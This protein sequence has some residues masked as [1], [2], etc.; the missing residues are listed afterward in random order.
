MTGFIYSIALNLTGQNSVMKAVEVTDRLDKSVNRVKGDSVAMGTAMEQAGRK[1]RASFDGM[2]SSLK[3]WIATA[4]IGLALMGSM[5]TAAAFEGTQNAIV[6]ASGSAE[7]GAK[8]IGFVRSEAERLGLQLD[9]SLNGFKLL[10]GAMRDVPADRVQNIFR[11]VMTGASAM[12]LSAEDANGVLLALSQIASKGKVQA[13]ELR[14]QI[15]ERIPGAFGIAARAMGVSEAALNK[16]METG[17]LASKDFLPRFAAQMEKEFG[18]AIAKSSQGATANFNRMSNAIFDLKVKFG[19][20]LLPAAIPFI[21]DFLIPGVTWIGQNI[22]L[23]LGLGVALTSAYTAYKLVTIAQAAWAAISTVVA[24]VTTGLTTGVWALN[25]AMYANPIGIV[26]ALLVGLA[27]A[28]VW[29]WNK[30]E[31]FRGFLLGMNEVFLEFHRIIYDFAIAPL[32]AMGKT[33]I[34]VFTFDK[35]MIAAGLMDS[36]ASFE[37]VSQGVGE[38]V[39]AAYQKGYGKGIAMDAIKMP[40]FLGGTTDAVSKAFGGNAP[41][42]GGTGGTGKD[43]GM[44]KGIEGI[45]GGGSKNITISVNK[46]VESLTIQSQNVKE[47]AGEMREIVIRELTQALNAM[48]MAQ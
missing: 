46:L 26:I 11:G 9:S 12:T 21:T 40:S 15:G 14:G 4:G 5:K 23:I 27:A 44:T 10:S 35:E 37:K 45:T 18:G 3:T 47:G 36:M 6:F 29:A 1:G 17:N 24:F 19:E 25:A 42:G 48:N 13:E 43:T 20:E 8:N 7:Q 34:G 41:A 32:M 30:F 16:M 38:R 28:T 33:L 2:T 31:G 22:D 39:G